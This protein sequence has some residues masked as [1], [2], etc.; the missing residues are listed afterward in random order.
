[1]SPFLE[2][3]ASVVLT[4]YWKPPGTSLARGMRWSGLTSCEILA[5]RDY[6]D[7]GMYWCGLLSG[8]VLFRLVVSPLHP[9]VVGPYPVRGAW[10]PNHLRWRKPVISRIFC[11]NQ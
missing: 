2:D 9:G 3:P 4:R 11:C 7:R 10:F 8:F 6:R 5:A 1:M